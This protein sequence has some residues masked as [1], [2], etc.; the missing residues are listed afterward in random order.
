M[1]QQLLHDLASAGTNQKVAPKRKAALLIV[2]T[3][4]S[5]PSQNQLMP[6]LLADTALLLVVITNRGNA[7][8]SILCHI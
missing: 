4:P 8:L 1:E 7:A 2:R 6:I 5:S 3:N